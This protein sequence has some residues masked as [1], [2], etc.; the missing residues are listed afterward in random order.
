[1]PFL[2]YQNDKVTFFKLPKNITTSWALQWKRYV[3]FCT[4]SFKIAIADLYRQ[5]VGI[6]CFFF[7]LLFFFK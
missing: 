1:M 5:K 4:L 7:S 3:F 6:M 2:C